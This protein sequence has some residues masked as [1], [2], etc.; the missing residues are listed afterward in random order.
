MKTLIVLL[1]ATALGAM[2]A[3][4][5]DSSDKSQSARAKPSS[6]AAALDANGD[7]TIDAGE[8]ANSSKALLRLDAN[9][10]GIL[11]DDELHPAEKASSEDRK[12]SRA[13]LAGLDGNRDGKLDPPE[14]ARAT[15][16]EHPERHA[17][18]RW[19]M[20]KCV[21]CDNLELWKPWI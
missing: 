13:L 11:S 10:D 4:A 3:Q 1:L 20:T 9:Q 8:I 2:T 5:Q 14:I 17:R 12:V 16:K 6:L 7:S 15:A 21:A 19:G 18:E